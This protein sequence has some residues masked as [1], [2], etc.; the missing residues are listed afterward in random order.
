MAHSNINRVVGGESI[1]CCPSPIS[2]VRPRDSKFEMKV[3][4]WH[5]RNGEIM[6]ETAKH[7]GIHRTT[8]GRWLAEV[9]DKEIYLR[10]RFKKTNE[11]N[12]RRYMFKFTHFDHYRLNEI[13][14]DMNM[15]IDEVIVN[16]IRE[17]VEGVGN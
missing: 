10:E 8:I 13:A 12:A 4:I 5:F 1:A 3:L 9:E 2:M 7:F 15:E 11:W 14:L 16:I 6:T 17:T